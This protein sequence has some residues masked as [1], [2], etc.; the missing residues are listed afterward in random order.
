RTC[1]PTRSWR[2]EGPEALGWGIVA[3]PLSAAAG[4][5]R[6]PAARQDGG[7][8]SAAV[9][10]CR[11][12]LA[13]LQRARYHLDAEAL[14]DVADAH[15]LVVL[16]GHAAF[17]AARHFRH[18]VLEALQR[19]QRAFVDHDVVADQADARAAL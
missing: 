12:I 3:V 4:W 7:G 10:W 2:C 18:F 15:V 11:P 1:S 13:R 16:E 14:D 5:D 6:E 17:L 8:I 9:E 19:L